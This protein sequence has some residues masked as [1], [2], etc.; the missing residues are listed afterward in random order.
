[1]ENGQPLKR[2]DE[3]DFGSCLE[4][5]LKNCDCNDQDVKGLL[6]V[7]GVIIL[8]I[9]IWFCLLSFISGGVGNPGKHVSTDPMNIKL[10]S[11]NVLNGSGEPF[12]HCCSSWPVSHLIL[13]FVLGL[14]FPNCDALVIGAG[15]LW[16]GVECLGGFVSGAI[17]NGK[18]QPRRNVETGSVEYMNWWSGSMK[19]IIVDIAGFYLG[20]LCVNVLD[21]NIRVKGINC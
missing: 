16:E 20:K 6:R 18:Y 19:D 3:V 10:F 14:L 5:S 1:M 9:I 12:E 21:L 2:P 7:F 11:M 17:Q 4:E 15:T 8:I 13:F